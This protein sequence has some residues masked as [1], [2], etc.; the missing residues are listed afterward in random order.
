MMLM[1]TYVATA[2]RT[3]WASWAAKNRYFL[4]EAVVLTAFVLVALLGPLLLETDPAEQILARVREKPNA[5]A[6]L[7][8]DELG[9]DILARLVHGAR[10][11]IG[12]GFAT[13]LFGLMIGGTLGLLSG[14]Y[15]KGIDM[16]VM[17]LMDMMLAF[18][19]ILLAIVMISILGTGLRNVVV[20]VGIYFVPI[21]ARLVRALSL[22]LRE[23]Q[24][25]LA[26]RAIGA[27][28]HRIMLRHLLPNMLPTVFVQ[29]TFSLGEGIIYVAGLGFLGLGVQPPTPEWGV[30]LS[31]ARE[32]M[33]VAPHVVIMPGLALVTLLLTLNMMGDALRDI[34]DPQLR[35]SQ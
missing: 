12:I 17:R 2:R 34:L 24:Y 27:A 28:D 3:N 23:E 31:R 10:Y 21:F 8:R 30:M 4:L 18:P 25:V 20:A 26:A 22:R 19:S 29:C 7:G 6:I 32:V 1:S 14:F 16:A 11:T 33:F 9:R 13:V 5:N 35:R 15:G